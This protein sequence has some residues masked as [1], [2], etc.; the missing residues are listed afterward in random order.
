[1]KK[2]ILTFALIYVVSYCLF[3]SCKRCETKETIITD[4]VYIEKVDSVAIG[5]I[6][7][8]LNAI[9]QTLQD[10]VIYYR[11]STWREKDYLNAKRCAKVN[12]YISICERNSSQ[13]K[14]FYG[15]IKRAMSD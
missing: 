1:M 9:I 7:D 6:R 8:S 11:D 2:I 12:Y 13:K 4:T 15:W 3:L 5:E 14:F 10:S